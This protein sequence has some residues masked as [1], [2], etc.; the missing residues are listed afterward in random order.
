[1]CSS[2]YGTK[3][4]MQAREAPGKHSPWA[5]VLLTRHSATYAAT[6]DSTLLAIATKWWS[7]ASR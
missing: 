6:T 5:A 7:L 1:M 3:T 4:V 2:R